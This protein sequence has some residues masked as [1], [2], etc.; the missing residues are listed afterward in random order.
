V[1][2]QRRGEGIVFADARL[3]L[4]GKTTF[5]GTDPADN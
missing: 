1:K 3:R 5:G 2:E 4:S